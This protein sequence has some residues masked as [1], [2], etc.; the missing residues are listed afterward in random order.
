MPSNYKAL[1]NG[2]LIIHINKVINRS[3]IYSK[4]QSTLILN[5]INIISVLRI[6]YSHEKKNSFVS[7]L[8]YTFHQTIIK[9]IF[10]NKMY[11]ETFI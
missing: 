5:L 1:I 10:M 8:V 3:I 2:Q 4:H 7:E 9:N 11:L 6:K